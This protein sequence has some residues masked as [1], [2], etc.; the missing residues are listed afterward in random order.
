[1]F[2]GCFLYL[3][4]CV[5]EPVSLDLE[6]HPE[7]V[8]NCFVGAWSDLPFPALFECGFDFSVDLFA[9][10]SVVLF[11]VTFVPYVAETFGDASSDLKC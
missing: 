6:R 9:F 11:C 8:V 1:M 3:L 7:D 5:L 2:C 10:C 4:D